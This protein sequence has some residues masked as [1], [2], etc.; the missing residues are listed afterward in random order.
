MVSNFELWEL[1]WQF[2]KKSNC[3]LGNKITSHSDRHVVITN[4]KQMKIAQIRRTSAN[5]YEII[6][7]NCIAC[8]RTYA[9]SFFEASKIVNDFLNEQ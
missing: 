1:E 4:I 8:V 9:G 7:A 3:A 2:V 5:R 6:K